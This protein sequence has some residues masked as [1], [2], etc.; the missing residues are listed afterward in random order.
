MYMSSVY[1]MSFMYY[2]HKLM[3][4]VIRGDSIGGA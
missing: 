2:V 4:T 3:Y 1:V